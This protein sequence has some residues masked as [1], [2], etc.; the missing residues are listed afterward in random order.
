M[1]KFIYLLIFAALATGCK[2][3]SQSTGSVE[4]FQLANYTMLDS[5]CQVNPSGVVL[6]TT[7]F[8][9]NVDIISYSESNYRYSLSAAAMERVKAMVG[10]Q[11]FAVAVNGETVFYGFYN[12]SILS[13]SCEHSVSLDGESESDDNRIILRLGYPGMLIGV[14]IEDKRNDLRII[15]AL[16][17]QG[18]WRQ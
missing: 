2:K 12:P 1:K 10:R 15:N 16:K 13:S 4:F 3:A 11:P 9:H 6:Q 18:K 17:A 14:P 7:P 5:K 8:I